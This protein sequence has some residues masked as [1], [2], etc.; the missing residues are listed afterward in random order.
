MKNYQ[1]TEW[2]HHFI[3]EHIQK[4]DICMDATMGNGHDTA[5]LSRLSGENGRV[6]AFDIQQMALDHTRQRLEQEHCP[7]NWELYLESHENMGCTP[8]RNRFPASRLIWDIC[9][10]VTIRK[11]PGQTAALRQFKLG[12]DF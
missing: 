10:E 3:T 5:L 11:L 9:R 2:V 6:L 4:G 12:W 7:S 8:S 1:I